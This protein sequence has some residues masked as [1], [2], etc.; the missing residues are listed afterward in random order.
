M[1]SARLFVLTAVFIAAGFLSGPAFAELP[2]EY[3]TWQDFAAV[4]AQD[5]IPHEIGVVEAI[6]RTQGGKFIVRSRSCTLEVTVF[7]ES[8][9]DAQGRPLIGPSHVARVEVGQKQCKP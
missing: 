2:P 4:V 5:S 6:E 9:K 8:A 1:A 3:T 7:R